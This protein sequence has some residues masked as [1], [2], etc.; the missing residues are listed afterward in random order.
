[1]DDSFLY[2][3]YDEGKQWSFGEEVISA[4]G[5]EW[6]RGRQDKSPHPFTTSFGVDD[7][8]ITTRVDRNS[9][10]SALFSTLHECGHAL[11]GLGIHPD[12]E[13]TPLMEGASLGVHESQSRTY[14]NLVGRSLPFWEY[15]YPRLQEYFPTQLGNVDLQNFY[16]GINKVE[17]P[18]SGLRPM[19]LLITCIS[20]CD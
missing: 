19:R 8:R 3:D 9:L 2:L 12:Y 5:F 11:Y 1:M 13:R 20:Y 14:E 15:F 10:P 6:E 18:S 17:P 7:V 16:K 4:Y